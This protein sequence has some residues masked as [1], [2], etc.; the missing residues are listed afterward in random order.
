M[1]GL[2]PPHSK[3]W[4]NI[5]AAR[6]CMLAIGSLRFS[7]TAWQLG[8]PMWGGVRRDAGMLFLD[9]LVQTSCACAH[10]LWLGTQELLPSG[11][12][13]GTWT[14]Q[15][16]TCLTNSPMP[17]SLQ[18][19]CSVLS[20]CQQ[21]SFEQPRP[22]QAVPPVPLV[23]VQQGARRAA[24][25]A[26]L[27]TPAAPALHPGTLSGASPVRLIRRW[28]RGLLGPILQALQCHLLQPAAS[29]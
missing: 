7:R 1:T 24:G 26:H 27:P 5:P 11:V 16:W 3:L 22:L 19:T 29:Q 15:M 23:A 6:F 8:L 18:A 13:Q 20:R 21:S 25:P 14:Y 4:F 9:V 12:F 10:G 28:G 17:P 2:H